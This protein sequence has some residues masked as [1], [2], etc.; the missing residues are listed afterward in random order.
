MAAPPRYGSMTF[1]FA[2]FDVRRIAL[3]L[4]DRSECDGIMNQYGALGQT[5]DQAANA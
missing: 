4:P 1:P 5:V 2:F 3:A